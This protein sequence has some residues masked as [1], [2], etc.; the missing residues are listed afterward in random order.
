MFH[1]N[2]FDL[3]H[4]VHNIW[5]IS[6]GLFDRLYHMQHMIFYISLI[7]IQAKVF[8]VEF[9]DRHQVM[10]QTVMHSINHLNHNLVQSNVQA[11]V[12]LRTGQI[13]PVVHRIIVTIHQI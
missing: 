10:I 7:L 13:G 12:Y 3:C 8:T 1:I 11:N 6:Y 5:L 2:S 9:M 4:I